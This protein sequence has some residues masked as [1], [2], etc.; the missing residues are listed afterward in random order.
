[1]KSGVTNFEQNQPAILILAANPRD[2]ARLR[3]DKE[4][5]EIDKGLQRS[6]NMFDLKQIWAVTP[7]DVH[8]AM[9]D[10]KPRFVHFCGHGEK[11]AGIILEDDAGN[12][13]PAGAEALAGLFELFAD[14]TE[15]VVLNACYSEVRAEAISR[16]INYGHLSFP[17]LHF[18]G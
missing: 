16:H 15:C 7:T 5:R 6:R 1:M 12:T 13:L 18:L 11:D 3:L 9:L 2:T 10:L 14:K 8:R 4:V 17:G